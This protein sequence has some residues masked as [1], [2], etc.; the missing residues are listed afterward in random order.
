LVIIVS[1]TFYA[2]VDF[3]AS[4][5]MKSIR[6]LIAEEVTVIRDGTRQTAPATDIVVGDVVVLTLV[7]SN[8]YSPFYLFIKSKGNRVPADIRIVEASSDLRFDR[9]L[10]TG[11][12]FI[13]T[14]FFVLLVLIQKKVT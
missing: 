1:A 11:E 14:L 6:N 4:R 3:H 12:R 2:V 10:L 8:F 9:S 7:S 5:I 13:S